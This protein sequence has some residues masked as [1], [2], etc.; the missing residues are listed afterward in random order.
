MPAYDPDTEALFAGALAAT[1]NP[2]FD[3]WHVGDRITLKDHPTLPDGRYEITGR[4]PQTDDVVVELTR[5]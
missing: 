3:T 2:I 1:A 5:V 4:H